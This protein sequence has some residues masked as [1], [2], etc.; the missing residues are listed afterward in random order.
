MKTI[1]EA[2]VAKIYLRSCCALLLITSLAKI[3]SATTNAAILV[4]PDPLFGIQ[5][6]AVLLLAAGVEL[7]VVGI[8]I[9][10]VRIISKCL[11]V[12]W[13]ASNFTL[14]RVGIILLHP[15]EPC[16]CLGNITQALHIPRN[17]ANTVAGIILCYLFLG[18]C[19]FLFW[20]R[21]Q[22]VKVPTPESS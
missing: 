6:R 10:D 7:L 3:Y 16:P 4:I 20:L 14:Y 22:N 18:S 5:N 2:L 1:G 12:C 21:R 13:L 9:L 19:G 8:L 15:H 11:T 17:T